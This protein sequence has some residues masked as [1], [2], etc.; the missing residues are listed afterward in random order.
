VVAAAAQAAV[1][2]TAG[3]R[4]PSPR[5]RQG[6][7]PAGPDGGDRRR[8]PPR[9]DR[10]PVAARR[11]RGLGSGP[12]PPGSPRSER[13]ARCQTTTSDI[14]PRWRRS[15]SA[16]RGRRGGWYRRLRANP[17]GEVGNGAHTQPMR[18][19]PDPGRRPPLHRPHPTA[20][21]RTRTS[22]LRVIRRRQCSATGSRAGVRARNSATNSRPSAR[23]HRL[24]GIT[25]QRPRF[26]TVRAAVRVP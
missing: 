11:R 16:S 4:R 5:R 1:H 15:A 3:C 17:D 13:W 26:D 22:R 21:A 18:A 23:V 12:I 14:S 8:S 20:P 19:R 10:A 24:V 6:A 9:A 7:A 25:P 2:S